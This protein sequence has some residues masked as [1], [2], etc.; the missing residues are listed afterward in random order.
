MLEVWTVLPYGNGRGAQEIRVLAWEET[1][2][3]DTEPMGGA[4]STHDEMVA[5]PR[6]AENYEHPVHT[7]PEV[8]D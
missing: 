8:D 6:D 7:H 1:L 4:F 3:G 2:H 5:K